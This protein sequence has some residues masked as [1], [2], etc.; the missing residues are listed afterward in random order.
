MAKGKILTEF[1][2]GRITEVQ[3]HGLSH[4]AIASELNRSKTAV[5]NF[6][7][8]PAEYG[9][10]K[11][12]GRPKTITPA[13]DRRIR[14]EVEEKSTITSAQIKSNTVAQCSA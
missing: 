4:R 12:T 14:R 7:K 11:F 9:T 5:T 6:L 2:R 13:L 10:K 3:K 8:N 1:Q